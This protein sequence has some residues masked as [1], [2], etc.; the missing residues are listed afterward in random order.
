MREIR[1][2]VG[3]SFLEQDAPLVGK[4]LKYF[5]QLQNSYPNFS[6]DHAETAKPADLAEK[7]LSVIQD[8]NVFIG[9]CTKKEKAIEPDLLVPIAFRPEYRKAKDVSFRWKTSDWIIQEIGLAK[10]RGLEIILL[11]EDN[12]REPG[13]LQGN[14][15]YIRFER[16]APEKS[17]GKILE[18]LSALSPKVAVASATAEAVS[19]SPESTA[20]VDADRDRSIDVHPRPEWERGDYDLAVTHLIIEGD[21][22]QAQEV[23]RAYLASADAAK[24]G[25]AASWKANVEWLRVIFGKGGSLQNLK[26]LA[27][28]NP[29][30][31]AVHEFL[32]KALA[33]YENHHAA[34]EHYMAAATAEPAA[35]D[36]SRLMGEA[37]LAYARAGDQLRVVDAIRNVR[38]SADAGEISEMRL[39]KFLRELAEFEKDDHRSML[40]MERIVDLEPEDVDTRFLLAHKHSEIGNNDLSLY[41]YLKIP[42]HSRATAVWNNLGVVFD[43]LGFPIKSVSAYQKAASRD[44]TLAM[45]NLG[46]KYLNE[47]FQ[48]KAKEQ[49]TQALAIPN[50]HQNIGL[51]LAD[52]AK[53]PEDENKKETE[54]LRRIKPKVEFYIALGRACARP[55]PEKIADRWNG[56]RCELV[57]TVSER[58]IRLVGTY[59]QDNAL[60]NVFL[61][62]TAS[63]SKPTTRYQVTYEG[64]LK[65]R[66]IEGTVAIVEEGR[67]VQRAT[68]LGMDPG[69][70]IVMFL[71]DDGKEIQVMENSKADNPAFYSLKRVAQA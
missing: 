37:A 64:V 32:A 68:V 8:K 51:L 48:D 21:E 38:G 44:E 56:P 4:F 28:A 3:H 14:I 31:A 18:M 22:Q 24:N 41:H 36:K 23:D 1:A 43:H 2:F 19:L 40:I 50:Y 13:G 67:P 55:E 27:T 58:K 15:E 5:S 52:L 34:A 12:V 61:F 60:A 71:T 33:I 20:V 35:E 66:T 53:R 42:Y 6:W 30:N 39:L 9:I 70:P 54:L 59:E 26:D 49:C 69:T 57:A 10:G 11:V 65:G 63:V 45:S 62:G 25:N 16:E 46:Y 47:G 7:V 17:F 29:S